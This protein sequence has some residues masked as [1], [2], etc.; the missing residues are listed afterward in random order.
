MEQPQGTGQ[1][2]CFLQVLKLHG[3][4][5]FC[6]S[7][8]CVCLCSQFSGKWDAGMRGAGSKLHLCGRFPVW[9]VDLMV[10]GRVVEFPSEG[11]KSENEKSEPGTELCERP[12][13]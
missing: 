4:Q 7:E 9:L 1:S 13:M 12:W 2:V 3:A 8:G 10:F 6:C 5:G 11:L